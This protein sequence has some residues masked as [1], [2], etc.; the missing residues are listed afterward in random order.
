MGCSG[1]KDAA[2]ASGAKYEDNK[3]TGGTSKK[4]EEIVQFLG[5]VPLFSTMTKGDR[6]DIAKKM[7][8]KAVKSGEVI[9]KQGEAGDEFF[10]IVQ[11]TAQV[12]VK[13][14]NGTV[15][16]VIALQTGDYFGEKAILQA[17]TRAAT[18]T[19]KT[20]ML[21]LSLKSSAFKTLDLAGKVAFPQRQA[22]Q[23]EKMDVF[24]EQELTKVE[25]SP[26]DQKLIIE[27][28]RA[29]EALQGVV[30]LSD[31]ML[32]DI[33]DV[34]EKQEV[35]KGTEIIKHGDPVA[36]YFYVLATGT[37]SV[38]V[39]EAVGSTTMKEVAT[40]TGPNSFG[41]VALLFNT[42]RTAA[43]TSSSDC[44]LW[45]INRLAFKR[46]LMQT[47][48][49]Q[50][51]EYIQFM[52][53]VPDLQKMYQAEKRAVAQA[54]TEAH[55]DKDDTVIK[56]GEEGDKLYLVY[57]GELKAYKD[58]K[59]VKD[60]ASGGYFGER[61][62][63]KREPRAATVK[64]VSATATLL[65]IDSE[66]FELVRS[67]LETAAQ[68]GR[69]TAAAATGNKEP[70]PLR[71]AIPRNE[72]KSMGY[73]GAGGFG[74]VSLE[75]HPQTNQYF[76]LKA[77][78][79]GHLVANDMKQSAC[80][81]KDLLLMCDSVFI[82]KLHGTYKDAQNLYF[83]LEACLA[84]DLYLILN[85]NQLHGQLPCAAYYSAVV[86]ESF[87]HLHSKRIVYRDLKPENLLLTD[88]GKAKL[89]DMGIAKAV[90]GRTYTLCGT[91]EY[92][93]PEVIQQK[94][95][96]QPVDWWTLGIFVFELLTGFT[97]FA[98]ASTWAIYKAVNKGIDK[99]SWPSVV[100]EG[101]HKSLV[102]DLCQPQPSRRLP[103]LP[104]GVERLKKKRLYASLDWEKLPTDDFKVPFV[105]KN[106]D[107]KTACRG[108]VN[109]RDVQALQTN[110]KDDGTNWDKDF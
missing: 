70:A 32:K 29:E 16:D 99:I 68:G 110:Y 40:K 76:A 50:L 38:T 57:K 7:T 26:E 11:G 33:S 49:A 63:L 14:D 27:A 89:C 94:G 36:K 28:V 25:K 75:H 91:P 23:A 96:G 2:P 9:I 59:E 22:V 104:A 102:Q 20:D 87:L 44:T 18:I 109:D 93:A 55:F 1:S 8:N 46:I 86:M 84:G 90:V 6:Q 13:L 5:E 67:S 17:E 80:T 108:R 85:R 64:V 60:Y 92:M 95:H 43:V 53:V 106:I 4:D 82:I 73:L 72:L 39:P 35:K 77:L 58:G 105:P 98:S 48:A 66:S 37:V 3:Q 78:S 41:G 100:S 15:K 51:E 83:L 88:K 61:A 12:S 54:L 74:F 69:T 81:E 62:L 56:E 79:K 107:P 47:S 71:T 101:G 45:R 30:D 34:A 42:P 52:N 24:S 103:M 31:Q 10:L 19:A 21:V 97:P 65:C